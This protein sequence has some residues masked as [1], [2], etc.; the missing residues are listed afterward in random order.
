MSSSYWGCKAQ[1]LQHSLGSL[2]ERCTK[3]LL[4]PNVL[5]TLL[6]HSIK[7]S[8]IEHVS[9]KPACRKFSI[10]SFYFIK[11]PMEIFKVPSQYYLKHQDWFYTV[12]NFSFSQTGSILVRRMP[13]LHNYN[14]Q[15]FRH[16]HF[17]WRPKILKALIILPTQRDFP[18]DYC[19]CMKG[20]VFCFLSM[21]Q[22][23]TMS[24]PPHRLT[25]NPFHEQSNPPIV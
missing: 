21:L 1:C 17:R 23:K 22:W 20:C 6:L 16:A 8:N 4:I 13:S 3:S 5:Y 9:A 7:Q 25:E 18:G 10:V 14:T 19:F 24:W 11:Q 15:S 2:E 12:C